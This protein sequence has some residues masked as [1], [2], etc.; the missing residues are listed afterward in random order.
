MLVLFCARGNSEAG[1]KLGDKV[2][3]VTHH[4]LFFNYKRAHAM[5]CLH[6]RLFFPK[7]N[8]KDAPLCN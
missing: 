8:E 2:L 7:E 6:P 5:I 1:L 3:E 4:L